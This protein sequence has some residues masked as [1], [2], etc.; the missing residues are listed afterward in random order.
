MTASPFHILNNESHEAV[1]PSDA[2][3]CATC[4][5]E[6]CGSI[7]LTRK[8]YVAILRHLRT[9][10]KSERDR[11][12]AQVREPVKCCFVD[13]E[14]WRCSIY[15]ARPTICRHFGYAPKMACHYA[16]LQATRMTDAELDAKMGANA[17]ESDG[18][19]GWVT[20]ITLDW[21]RIK[22]DLIVGGNPKRN[23]ADNAEMQAI[24]QMG[25]FRL[26]L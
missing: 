26:E 10:P 19:L 5:S 9:M 11:L 21:N 17:A 6:C 13:T 2:F 23:A 20:G 16:P 4:A 8:E 25:K 22:R 14:H 1:A 12:A 3:P 24:A 18:E 15:E 7:P